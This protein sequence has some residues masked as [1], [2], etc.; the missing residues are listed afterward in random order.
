[1]RRRWTERCEAEPVSGLAPECVVLDWAASPDRID[2]MRARIARPDGIR[3]TE[4]E[5]KLGD[6][7][8]VEAAA[9]I[10]GR[11]DLTEKRV[12]LDDGAAFIEAGRPIAIS[13]MT[14]N[15]SVT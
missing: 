11:R 12:A 7:P 13:R 1:M 3:D 6:S 5:W 15:T 14:H 9:A 10:P 4:R 2:L 8:C